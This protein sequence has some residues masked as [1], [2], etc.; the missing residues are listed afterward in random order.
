[1]NVSHT[2]MGKAVLIYML[3]FSAA[4]YVQARF[5]NKSRIIHWFTRLSG[6]DSWSS[7]NK[8]RVIM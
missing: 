5:S 3:D 8:S 6:E 2:F 4:F 1:M 7:F